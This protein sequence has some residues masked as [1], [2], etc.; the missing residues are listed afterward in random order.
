MMA[1]PVRNSELGAGTVLAVG[2]GLMLL[3]AVSA[4]VLLAQAAVLATKAA[5]AADLA[6]LAAADAA[7]GLSPGEPCAVAA[8]VAGRH[9]ARL[10]SC[11][12]ASGTV[13]VRTE[14]PFHGMFGSA[15][16]L[17]RAGPPPAVEDGAP[18]PA[19]GPPG[20]GDA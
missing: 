19:R 1:V 6:A 18:E 3:L 16:G 2:L 9:G 10:V 8:E 12:V 13:Q 5:S 17:A 4:V 15:T 14:L 20:T 11:S 7:R